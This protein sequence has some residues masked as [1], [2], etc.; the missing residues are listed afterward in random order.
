M[1]KSF[2]LLAAVVFCCGALFFSSGAAESAQPAATATAVPSE[3]AVVMEIHSGR[4]IY[5]CNADERRPMASTTKI[6]TAITVIESCGDLDREV[7]V[8]ENCVGVEGSSIYLQEGEVLTVRQILYGLMLQSGNDCAETLACFSAGSI[9]KFA[10]QM[11][12]KA[13]EIGAA[14]SHFVNPHGLHDPDHFTTARDLA[15][16]SAYAMKNAT[17]REIV[18]TRKIQIPWANHDY[19]RVLVNKNKML[20][21]F[22]GATGIKT[23]FTKAAGRCLVSSAKRDSGEYV[24]V[25]LNCP[26]MFERS[27]QLLEDAFSNYDCS[28]IFRKGEKLGEIGIEG[29]D[30]VL[31]VGLNCD[32]A[33]PLTKAERISLRVSVEIR[34]SVP[35][36]VRMEE[37]VGNIQVYNG[38]QLIFSQKLYTILGSI[39]GREGI[40]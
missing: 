23:G 13:F 36:P 21:E 40:E 31:D 35:A 32:F 26:P 11:N 15:I 27:K 19:P 38:N 37:S 7:T 33:Y 28:P 29:T 1:I 8:P 25:V 5:E 30:R 18:S 34:P 20:N 3:S 4:V 14:H 16:I 10:D 9:G 17:F 12:R 2:K 39:D 6:L 24:C 22:E